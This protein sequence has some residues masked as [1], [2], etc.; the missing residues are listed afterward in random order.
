MYYWQ[1]KH[2]EDT[3]TGRDKIQRSTNGNTPRPSIRGG[4][5]YACRRQT[6]PP[7]DI[8]TA[9]VTPCRHIPP[10]E[11]D[12]FTPAAI[13]PPS[14]LLA[15]PEPACSATKVTRLAAF[16]CFVRRVHPPTSS[17]SQPCRTTTAHCRT[18]SR[19]RHTSCHRN[20][21]FGEKLT[22]ALP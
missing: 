10:I 5:R 7:P 22:M 12:A 8:A 16:V 1:K 17:V 21:S 11:I 3:R 2:P 6:H 4:W 19:H 9:H 18:R 13:L 15:A 20:A 14:W